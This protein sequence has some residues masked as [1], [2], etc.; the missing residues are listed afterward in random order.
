MNAFSLRKDG[1]HVLE[2]SSGETIV[3]LDSSRRTM[4]TTPYS[5]FIRSSPVYG[6]SSTPRPSIGR[7]INRY[8]TKYHRRLSFRPDP[9]PY[10][11]ARWTDFL[12][13]GRKAD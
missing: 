13:R 10:A 9:Y 3:P 2:N 11:D 12:L 5:I 8:R 1:G 6:T 4:T 7:T